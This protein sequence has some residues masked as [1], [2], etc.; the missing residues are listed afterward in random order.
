MTESEHSGTGR[1]SLSSPPTPPPGG[2]GSWYDPSSHDILL[3]PRRLRG[4][5]HPIRVRLLAMLQDDGPAT[6]SQLGRRLGRSSGVT[7][8]HV[9]ILAG[10]GFVEDDTERGN[11]RDR[12]WRSTYRIAGFTVRSPDDPGD[13]ENIEIVTQYMRACVETFNERMVDYVDSLALRLDDLPTLPW[14]FDDQPVTL[15]HDEAR[16]LAGDIRTLV[17]RYHRERG[18]NGADV[19]A[20]AV[21]AYFQFQLLPD[22][23][24]DSEEGEQQ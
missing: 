8:Y 7:S 13:A 21:R 1:E 19:P 6:A 17:D 12:W 16:A 2:W 10:L 15:T 24:P 14:T 11:G 18:R 20:G 4:L 22:D 9:R 3:T 5:A 23:L